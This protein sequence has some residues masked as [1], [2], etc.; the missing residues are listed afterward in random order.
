MNFKDVQNRLAV[1]V[2]QYVIE[3]LVE[4]T[5]AIQDVFVDEDWRLFNEISS[6]EVEQFIALVKAI[7]SQT[8][9]D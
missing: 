1:E 7:I 6:D 5:Q 8:K 4:I 2:A 3:Y 9:Q